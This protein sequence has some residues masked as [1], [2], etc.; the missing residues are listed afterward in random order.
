[1]WIKRLR[2]IKKCGRRA[3]EII[4]RKY[5]EL[6]ELN[7]NYSFSDRSGAGVSDLEFSIQ[8][9]SFV[10]Y[11]FVRGDRKQGTI[12]ASK[13]IL[14]GTHWQIPN[15]DAVCATRGIDMQALR[16][17]NLFV[18]RNVM[19]LLVGKEKEQGKIQREISRLNS[20]Q[21]EQRPRWESNHL[22]IRQVQNPNKNRPESG[23]SV[24]EAWQ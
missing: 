15:P 20:D 11:T 14:Q 19:Y 22:W 2:K 13:F 17:R 18:D 21:S 23:W 3:L 5:Q 8:C 6:T 7:K 16:T 10:Y 4:S 1:M 9:R 24:S 12:R